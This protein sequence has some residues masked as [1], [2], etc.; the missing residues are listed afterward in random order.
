L[1]SIA[2]GVTA[3]WL[4]IHDGMAS[5]EAHALAAG[6]RKVPVAAGEGRTVLEV[7]AGQE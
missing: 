7:L 3:A 5:I 2:C 1:L 6:E 4:T